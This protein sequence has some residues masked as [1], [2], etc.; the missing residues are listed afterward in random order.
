MVESLFFEQGDGEIFIA[1]TD[2][3]DRMV[4]C[5]D[6]STLY[7]GKRGKSLVLIEQ[8]AGYRHPCIVEILRWWSL[9]DKL[10]F[11][12]MEVPKYLG[13]WKSYC[14]RKMTM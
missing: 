7:R 11:I 13:Q 6:I 9:K 8:L 2:E 5:V 12:E 1:K 14:K 10:I 3:G 4:T